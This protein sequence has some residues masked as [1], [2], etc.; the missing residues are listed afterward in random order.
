MD[1]NFCLPPNTAEKGQK[2]RGH[3]PGFFSAQKHVTAATAYQ[4]AGLN[5]FEA[6]FLIGSTVSVATFWVS[7]VSS[8]L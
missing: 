4:A 5:S 6:L 1:V 8:L 2:A 7:S 3:R